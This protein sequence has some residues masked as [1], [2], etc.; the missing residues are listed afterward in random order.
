MRRLKMQ[1]P[2]MTDQI[3]WLKMHRNHDLFF[4]FSSLRFGLSF[5]GLANSAPPMR[6]P[7]DLPHRP[8]VDLTRE[9][10]WL[11]RGK[12]SCETA[13][14]GRRLRQQQRRSA[15]VVPEIDLTVQLYTKPFVANVE[16]SWLAFLALCHIV[17][18]AF[19][20]S[21]LYKPAVID[22]SSW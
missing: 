20:T 16:L 4:H 1:D 5:S 22:L 8:R 19:Y 6:W 18:I 3:A 12:L 13:S 21:M 2:R 10:S 17:V 9:E 15:D 7:D 14:S 11:A